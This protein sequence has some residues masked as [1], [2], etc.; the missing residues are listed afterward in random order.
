LLDELQLF[1]L[2]SFFVFGACL[3]SFAN[4]VIYRWP[5]GLSVVSPRSHCFNCKKEVLWRHNI[6]LFSWL[7][8]KGKCAFCQQPFSVRYSLIEWTMAILFAAV[9]F[10]FGLTW[11][12]AEYLLLV[13]GLV[14]ISFI[15]LDHFLIPDVFSLTGIALGVAGS[16]MNPDRTFLDSLLGVF[17]GGGFLWAIA[18]IYFYLRKEEGMGGGDIKL[19]A[20]IGAVLGWKCIPFVILSASTVGAILG[21]YFARK[22]EKG[23]KAVIP[24]GPYLAA[25]AL[26]YMFFG[27]ELT[28]WY[29]SIF[30]EDSLPFDTH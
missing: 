23:V 15:D 2:V 8:L 9:Y 22:S 12:A 14:T 11:T 25:G 6:P 30:F 16:L 29:L 19:L 4:V 13:F 27:T 18:V 17:L 10:K 21:L 24:F 3:G 7:L 1:W 5:L 28:V 20:W 26:A